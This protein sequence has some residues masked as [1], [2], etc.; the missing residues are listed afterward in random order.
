MLWTLRTVAKAVTTIIIHV[1][2]NPLRATSLAVL[3]VEIGTAFACLGVRG[4]KQRHCQSGRTNH[5][6][7]CKGVAVAHHSLFTKEKV[8]HLPLQDNPGNS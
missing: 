5:C 2:T 6:R 3:K 8:R 4:N 1:L 7:R